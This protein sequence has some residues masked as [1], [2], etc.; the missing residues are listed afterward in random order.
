MIKGRNEILS[1]P[2]FNKET[3]VEACEIFSK[4]C[5]IF[6]FFLPKSRKKCRLLLKFNFRNINVIY[7]RI[8]FQTFKRGE[9]LGWTRSEI[10]KTP[11]T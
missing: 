7:L 6:G 8:G 5:S 11:R 3:K 1:V 9:E 2:A 10:R 4:E